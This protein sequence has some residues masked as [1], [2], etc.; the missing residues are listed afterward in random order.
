MS[1]SVRWP[2]SIHNR[3]AATFESGVSV[4]PCLL[5]RD[6]H[7]GSVLDFSHSGQ[8]MMLGEATVIRAMQLAGVV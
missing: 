3:S 5:T 2:I 6:F 7:C 1:W 4:I 8:L